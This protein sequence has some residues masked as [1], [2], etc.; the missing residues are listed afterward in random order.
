M[1]NVHKTRRLLSITAFLYC[2]I[3]SI[4]NEAAKVRANDRE[5]ITY[6]SFECHFVLGVKK[7]LTFNV[8]FFIYLLCFIE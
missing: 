5:I 3:A 1:F 6:L 8:L 4:Q 2:K 7:A